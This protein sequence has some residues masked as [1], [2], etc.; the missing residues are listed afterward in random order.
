MFRFPVIGKITPGTKT[1]P[2][3]ADFG[4]VDQTHIPHRIKIKIDTSLEPIIIHKITYNKSA[5]FFLYF[6]SI[7]QGNAFIPKSN[8]PTILGYITFHSFI[9][10]NYEGKVFFI[11][12][13]SM[14]TKLE[15]RARVVETPLLYGSKKIFIDTSNQV[16]SVLYT[17]NIKIKNNLNEPLNLIKTEAGISNLTSDLI[18]NSNW[19]STEFRVLYPNED[20]IGRAHV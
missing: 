8:E 15:L 18:L 3:I 9:P 19:P 10:G 14:I 1:I 2:G 7:G 20:Q 4:T 12:N 5:D 11:T 17:K 6:P 16:P 13:S